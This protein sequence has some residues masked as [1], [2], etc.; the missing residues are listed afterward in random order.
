MA[1]PTTNWN[2][3]GI[4]AVVGPLLAAAVSQVWNR[5]IKVKD[6]EYEASRQDIMADR[7]ADVEI[8]KKKREQLLSRY[9]EMKD[10]CVRFLFGAH[11]YFLKISD[12]LKTPTDKEL[13]TAAVEAR[14]GFSRSYQEVG[15]LGNNEISNEATKVW[16]TAIE[17]SESYSIPKKPECVEFVRQYYEARNEFVVAAKKYLSELLNSIY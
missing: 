14:E 3:L 1:D 2:I 15:L 13:R 10:V 4:W 12:Y 11:E 17:L 6:R 9:E 8:D 7:A 16:N 5:K